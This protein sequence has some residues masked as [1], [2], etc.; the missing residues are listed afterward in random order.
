MRSKL[1]QKCLAANI[2]PKLEAL[3]DMPPIALSEIRKLFKTDFATMSGIL[4]LLK[5]AGLATI[6]GN[7]YSFSKKETEFRSFI[8]ERCFEKI[9]F[10]QAFFA[11]NDIIAKEQIYMVLQYMTPYYLGIDRCELEKF[12]AYQQVSSDAQS[13][14]DQLS[15]F[16]LVAFVEDKLFLQCD[17]EE[18]LEAIKA[19][20]EESAVSPKEGDALEEDDES[21]RLLDMDEDALWEYLTKDTP[22]VEYEGSPWGGGMESE[23]EECSEENFFDDQEDEDRESDVS[24][25]QEDLDLED[26]EEG[27]DGEEAGPPTLWAA[28]FYIFTDLDDLNKMIPGLEVPNSLSP[29][30]RVPKELL[31]QGKEYVFAFEFPVFSQEDFSVVLNKIGEYLADW[32]QLIASAIRYGAET[33]FLLANHIANKESDKYVVY[34]SDLLK[35]LTE[36]GS[37]VITYLGAV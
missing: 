15:R 25:D 13:L 27:E 22:P 12:L 23:E 35:A 6:K 32:Q 19:V 29:L 7:R 2:V 21:E 11:V 10:P 36:I 9:G 1:S 24:A 37:T 8:K 20:A 34:P 3:A 30:N 5:E 26:E 33:A 18:V 4:N 17:P 16:S 31:P 14:F 28:G